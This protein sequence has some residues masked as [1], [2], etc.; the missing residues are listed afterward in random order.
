MSPYLEVY[1]D[2]DAVIRQPRLV[3]YYRVLQRA[4]NELGLSSV[5]CVNQVPTLYRV[6]RK[7]VVDAGALADL[8][9]KF[10]NQGVASVLLV[11]DPKTAYLFSG[12]QRPVRSCQRVS[13]TGSTTRK[14]VRWP[15]S[16]SMSPCSIPSVRQR[17]VNT[18]PNPNSASEATSRVCEGPEQAR[19]TVYPTSLA[20]FTRDVKLDR[21]LDGREE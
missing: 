15:A 12:L 21:R 10:W 13:F 9:R 2:L 18:L 14:P 4:W 11:V 8:H 17:S 19:H 7:Q 1:E 5:L 20:C 3:G 16:A 6:D